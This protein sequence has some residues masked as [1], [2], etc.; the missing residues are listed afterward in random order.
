MAR[1]DV[2]FAHEYLLG[3]IV[4]LNW[5]YG[6]RD[7]Y[8]V[9]GRP[10]SAQCAAHYVILNAALDLHL[11]LCAPFDYRVYGGWADF[12]DKSEAPRLKLVASAVAVPDCA[13]T[14]DPASLIRVELSFAISDATTIFH[15][16]HQAL[17]II[18]TSI[19]VSVASTWH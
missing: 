10:T 7:R 6:F 12:E 16:R 15:A 8:L 2:E 13:A 19:A 11:R 3:V 5:M 17:T 9:V 14:C 1:E 18:L 4:G